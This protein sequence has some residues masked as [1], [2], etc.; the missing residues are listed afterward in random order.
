MTND[1]RRPETL[2]PREAIHAK[3]WPDG[4]NAFDDEPELLPLAARPMFSLIEL[5]LLSC[6]IGILLVTLYIGLVWAVRP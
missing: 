1:N 6:M 5:V 2:D 4:S 3:P